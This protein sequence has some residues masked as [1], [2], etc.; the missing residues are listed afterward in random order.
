MIKFIQC[1]KRRPELSVTEFRRHLAEYQKRVTD[2]ADALEAVRVTVSS[3]LQVEQNLEIQLTRGTT[4]PYDGVIEIWFEKAPD[5]L[6]EEEGEEARRLLEQMRSYQE[7][8]A[9]LS[10]SSFFFA[11]EHEVFDRTGDVN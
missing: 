11:A 8:F 4:D 2:V 6:L 10:A 9:D 1:M 3:T 5:I 7:Q